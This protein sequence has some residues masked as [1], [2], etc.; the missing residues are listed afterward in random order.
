MEQWLRWTP[1]IGVSEWTVNRVR[2]R[3]LTV[4]FWAMAAATKGKARRI[5][6]RILV[7]VCVWCES[8]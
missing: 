5:E 7:I 2:S 6:L 3:T 1:G 8:V 4:T